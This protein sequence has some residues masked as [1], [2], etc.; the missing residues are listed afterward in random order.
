M[1]TYVY[2]ATRTPPLFGRIQTEIKTKDFET[3]ISKIPEIVITLE[4]KGYISSDAASID[5]IF[6]IATKDFGVEEIYQDMKAGT[7][8]TFYRL[9]GKNKTHLLLQSIENI[10]HWNIG[11]ISEKRFDKIN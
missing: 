11:T 10:S 1:E 3:A 5:N 2:I 4:E 8:D 7:N 6:F 9:I